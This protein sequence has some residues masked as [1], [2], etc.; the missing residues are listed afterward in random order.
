MPTKHQDVHIKSFKFLVKNWTNFSSMHSYHNLITQTR[1]NNLNNLTM[2]S[3]IFK[4]IVFTRV[5]RAKFL[6]KIRFKI[7]SRVK[8]SSLPSSELA[9]IFEMTYLIL[10]C[11][12]MAAFWSMPSTLSPPNQTAS[13]TFFPLTAVSHTLKIHNQADSK[14]PSVG[15][16][17]TTIVFFS[18]WDTQ[19]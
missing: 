15:E 1:K 6:W 11:T 7:K 5:L 18:S 10:N 14:Q 2:K 3:F 9:A 8:Y 16:R 4:Y 12:E 17:E 19:S 13:K